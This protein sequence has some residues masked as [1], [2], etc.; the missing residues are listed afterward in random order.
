MK[1]RLLIL[2]VLAFALMPLLGGCIIIND[3]TI[4]GE[5]LVEFTWSGLGSGTTIVEFFA[6]HTFEAESGITTGV[7]S[8]SGKNIEFI[9]D[10][11]PN[12]AYVGTVKWNGA[13]MSGT[14]SNSASMYGTWKATK[15]TGT[16][17][18]TP[19]QPSLNG[20]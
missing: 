12:S 1:A 19:G 16:L 11:Y 6:N 20:N 10:A 14:M 7:W 3:N 8:L 17:S 4:I 2:A 13:S 15:G 9:C 5:W 18:K